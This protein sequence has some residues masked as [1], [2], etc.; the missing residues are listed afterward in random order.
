MKALLPASTLQPCRY[1]VFMYS[2]NI[3]IVRL[4][5]CPM[6]ID[7]WRQKALTALSRDYDFVNPGALMQG[8]NQAHFPVRRRWCSRTAFVQRWTGKQYVCK[9]TGLSYAARS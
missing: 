6:I 2:L 9:T 5:Y 8:L 1:D 3:G 4:G 7:P